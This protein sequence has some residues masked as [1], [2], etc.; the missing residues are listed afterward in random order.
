MGKEVFSSNVIPEAVN[1]VIV[2]SK[3]YQN[4]MVEELYKQGIEAEKIYTLY[5]REDFVDLIAID[6]ILEI[7]SIRSK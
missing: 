7:P 2:S 4:Q 1:G 3:V 6:N 5:K